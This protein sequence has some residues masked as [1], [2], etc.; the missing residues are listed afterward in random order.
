MNNFKLQTALDELERLHDTVKEFKTRNGKLPNPDSDAG[1]A[2]STLEAF[3][4]D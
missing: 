4:G 1:R 3:A 2:V